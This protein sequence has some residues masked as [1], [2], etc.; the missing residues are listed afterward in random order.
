MV[1]RS[2]RTH[3]AYWRVTFTSRKRCN[4]PVVRGPDAEDV[5]RAP[6]L[7]LALRRHTKYAKLDCKV[8]FGVLGVVTY[9]RVEPATREEYEQDRRIAFL[10]VDAGRGATH[11]ETLAKYERR[12]KELN[13]ELRLKKFRIIR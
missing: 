7:V 1:E 2:R 6:S 9:S 11:A 5:V 3:E 10:A 12:R 8:G 13:R 4:G